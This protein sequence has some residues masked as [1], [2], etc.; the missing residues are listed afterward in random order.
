LVCA[1]SD[2]RRDLDK[3]EEEEQQQG[4][5]PPP[6]IEKNKSVKDARGVKENSKANIQ[7]TMITAFKKQFGVV[8]QEE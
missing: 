4:L 6:L 3:R 7:Q 5:C 2:E 8:C 1:R